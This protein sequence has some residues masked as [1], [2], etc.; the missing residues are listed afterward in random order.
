MFVYSNMNLDRNL[1]A[2]LKT[3]R[4]PFVFSVLGGSLM[5]LTLIYKARI[6]SVVLK[7]VFLDHKGLSQVQHFLLILLLTIFFQFSFSILKEWSAGKTSQIIKTGLRRQFIDHLYSLGPIAGREKST[8]ELSNLIV[9]GIDGI[10][11]YF[12]Q[13]LP[14]LFLSAIVPIS[15]LVFIFPTDILSGVVLLLTAPLIPFFMILIGGAAQKLTQ[16]QWDSLIRMSAYFLDIFQ[17]IV[18]LKLFNRSKAQINEIKKISEKFHQSTMKVLRVAFLSAL[19]LEILASISTAIIAVEI[20]LRLLYGQFDFESAMFILILAPEFY[21]PLRRLGAQ[22]HAGQESV[23]AAQKLYDV[24]DRHPI[25]PKGIVSS[26]NSMQPGSIEFQDVSFQYDTVR[27]SAIRHIDLKLEDGKFTA[28]VGPSGAG[29]STLVRLILKFIDPTEGKIVW[30]GND[31]STIPTNQW[32]KTVS[33]IPQSPYMFHAS[34][35][36]NID[37]GRNYAMDQIIEAAKAAY[38]HD[39]IL[40]LPQGYDTIIG[41]Q[42]AR[43]SGGQIQRVALAR[44]FLKDSPILILDEPTSNLD[45]QAESFIFKAMHHLIKNRTVLA[46]VHKL[47]TIEFADQIVVLNHGEVEATGTHAELIEQRK[48]YYNLVSAHG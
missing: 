4:K 23:A 47:K 37:I 19:V 45:P 21:L 17:G 20:G 12:S 7:S 40:S 14:E 2:L 32:R 8:G 22:F 3:A 16:K 1:L 29:K 46:I 38:L 27:G 41:E 33:Y 13:Y 43:L 30:G 31:L 18:T 6:L 11:K 26:I 10:D 44:A 35:K 15:I 48:T 9:E 28:L 34:V 25:V 5:G 42:G 24:L 36:D 39:F